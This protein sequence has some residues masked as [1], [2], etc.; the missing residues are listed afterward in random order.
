MMMMMLMHYCN[1]I[2]SK[3]CFKISFSN[4]YLNFLRQKSW[5][6]KIKLNDR[7]LPSITSVL[8]KGDQAGDIEFSGDMSLIKMAIKRDAG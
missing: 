4:L 6:L 1:V 5:A 2:S 3:L 7:K 8:I